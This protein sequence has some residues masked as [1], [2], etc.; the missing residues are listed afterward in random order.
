MEANDQILAGLGTAFEP[1]NNIKQLF[2][3]VKR[4]LGSTDST[5][6]STSTTADTS[7]QDATAAQ[8][9]TTSSDT[10]HGVTPLMGG[11]LTSASAAGF[12]FEPGNII[13]NVKV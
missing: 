13:P 1:G 12:G 8:G 6:D 2:N 4:Q 3:M 5:S 7:S 9:Y 10:T 11:S